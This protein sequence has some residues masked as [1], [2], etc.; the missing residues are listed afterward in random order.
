MNPLNYDTCIL[1]VKGAGTQKLFTNFA[2]I[3]DTT[4]SSSVSTGSLINAGGFGNSGRIT[5]TDLTCINSITGKNSYCIC[6]TSSSTSLS[7][8]VAFNAIFTSPTTINNGLSA[9]SN[10]VITI[11]QTGT[12]LVSGYV[13]FA[14]NSSGYR[15]TFYQLSSGTYL[16]ASIVGNITMPAIN[17]AS[18]TITSSIMMLLTANTTVSIIGYQNSGSSLNVSGHLSVTKITS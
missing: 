16:G 2:K 4:A 9:N 14:S 10:G 13:I 18:H 17:G 11:S 15:E 8:G 6:H 1:Q 12:Y 7:S 3:T 5:T